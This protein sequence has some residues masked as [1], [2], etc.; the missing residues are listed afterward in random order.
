MKSNLTKQNLHCQWNYSSGKFKEHF[1]WGSDATEKKLT[2]KVNGI[3]KY[4][5]FLLRLKWRTKDV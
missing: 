3:T 4:G 5:K 2:K 1:G